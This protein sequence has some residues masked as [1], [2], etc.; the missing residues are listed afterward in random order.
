[1]RVLL[2]E[3]MPRRLKRL[4]TGHDVQTVPE[5]GWSGEKNGALLTLA[6]GA[7]DVLVTVDQ[8][9]E[10]QQRFAGRRISVIVLVSPTN[11]FE[12]LAPLLPQLQ[13]R[14]ETAEPGRVYSVSA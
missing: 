1:M 4:L 7:F 5:A 9:L 10:H 6:E 13:S 14:L 12:D 11:R 2:D 8:N 3:C